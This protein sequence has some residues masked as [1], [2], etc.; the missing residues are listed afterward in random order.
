MAETPFRRRN[1]V[2]LCRKPLP[3]AGVSART[4]HA[5]GAGD[6]QG[7][8]GPVSSAPS[9]V[10]PR[11]RVPGAPV[12]VTCFQCLMSERLIQLE[13]EL[14]WPE[15]CS[16]WLAGPLCR[17]N[18]EAASILGVCFTPEPPIHCSV[19]A[20]VFSASLPFKRAVLAVI[21][22]IENQGLGFLCKGLFLTFFVCGMV[23]SQR[24]AGHFGV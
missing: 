24:W 3:K 10:S 15:S 8:S 22:V 1:R 21:T 13:G 12:P 11:G 18:A 6:P 23:P 19:Q 5:L 14:H 2:Y 9:S 20:A 16:V 7:W 17:Q 4:G